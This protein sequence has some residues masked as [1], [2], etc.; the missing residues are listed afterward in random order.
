MDVLVAEP[1]LQL[2]HRHPGFQLMGGIGMAQGMDAPD[3][4]DPGLALG[5]G[6]RLLYTGEAERGR[7]VA[8][9]KQPLGRP[10]CPPVTAQ[11]PQQCCRQDHIP[12][13]GALRLSTRSNRRSPSRWRTLSATT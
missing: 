12:I 4:V 3:L 10:H 5:R 6:K 1:S 2:M 11:Q 8:P 7:K 9:G 13:L